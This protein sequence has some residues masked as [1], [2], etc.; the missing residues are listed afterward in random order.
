MLKS[1]TV[2]RRLEKLLEYYRA[3]A[4]ESRAF[5]DLP[6]EL[7]D[8]AKEMAL[9]LGLSDVATGELVRFTAAQRQAQLGVVHSKKS[10]AQGEPLLP[11]VGT[12]LRRL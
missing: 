12:A 9:E 10:T 6:E 2:N 8:S 1:G 4:G 5:A 11:L 3:G 7:R